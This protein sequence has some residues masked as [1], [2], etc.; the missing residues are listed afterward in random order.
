[1]R[2]TLGAVMR[3]GTQALVVD[4]QTGADLRALAEAT[5][6]LDG[7]FF[8]VGSGGLARELAF[9]IDQSAPAPDE[10]AVPSQIYGQDGAVLILVGSLSAVSERQ[11]A[12][13]REH[14][15]HRRVRGTARLAARRRGA[16]EMAGLA[17]PRG[18]APWRR[19]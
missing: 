12:M 19:H 16:S 17:G 14:G 1:M 13:L 6:S 7:A 9:V 11:C 10:N 5:A 18:R 2:E 15:G 4:A 3:S 8:W